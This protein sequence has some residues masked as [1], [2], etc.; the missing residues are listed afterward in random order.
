MFKVGQKV[1][2]SWGKTFY[3]FNGYG[4][5]GVIIAHHKGGKKYEVSGF[6]PDNE[7]YSLTFES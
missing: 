7:E 4:E 6:N 3:I 1:K 2:V 5:E